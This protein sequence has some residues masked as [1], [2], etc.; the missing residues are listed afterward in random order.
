MRMEPTFCQDQEKFISI[1][2]ISLVLFCPSAA[3][4]LLRKILPGLQI[5][6]FRKGL[7]RE[8]SGT[9]QDLPVYIFS[10]MIQFWFQTKVSK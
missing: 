5:F 2:H 4:E 10:L 1:F 6:S 9:Y 3:Q 8:K 7:R